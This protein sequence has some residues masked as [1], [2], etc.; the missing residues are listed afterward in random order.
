MGEAVGIVDVAPLT[1]S[2]RKHVLGREAASRAI[3]GNS[4]PGARTAKR[5][6]AGPTVAGMQTGVSEGVRTQRSRD[7]DHGGQG[8][9]GPVFEGK[10]GCRRATV[11]RHW[12]VQ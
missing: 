2:L 3:S 8:R 12:G 7:P 9:P 4:F 5:G 6:A 10:S 1:V 11:Q